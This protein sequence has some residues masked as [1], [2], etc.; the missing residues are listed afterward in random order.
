MACPAVI[1]ICSKAKS[2]Q[3]FSTQQ[4]FFRKLIFFVLFWLVVYLYK[5]PLSKLFFSSCL[6]LLSFSQRSPTSWCYLKIYLIFRLLSLFW[7]RAQFFLWMVRSISLIILFSRMYHSL[8]SFAFV[9]PIFMVV[10]LLFVHFFALSFL[11]FS[12]IFS[13]LLIAIVYYLHCLRCSKVFVLTVFAVCLSVL[14]KTVPQA[15]SS[16]YVRPNPLVRFFGLKIRDASH[17]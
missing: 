16:H 8:L 11:S 2:F 15:L 17:Y 7:L 3:L 12:F 1:F 5:V 14:A 6:L 9:T 13:L 4:F 10:T